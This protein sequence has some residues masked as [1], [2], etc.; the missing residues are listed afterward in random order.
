MTA[1]NESEDRPLELVAWVDELREAI[2]SGDTRRGRA[3]HQA[4]GQGIERA[5]HRSGIVVVDLARERARR[6]G[7]R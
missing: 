7:R 3:A 1:P 5:S 2:R 4:I 6:G